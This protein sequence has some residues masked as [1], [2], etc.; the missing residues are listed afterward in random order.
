MSILKGA[1]YSPAHVFFI[2][3]LFEYITS[4]KDCK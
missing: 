3:L 4:A 1:Q 2:G